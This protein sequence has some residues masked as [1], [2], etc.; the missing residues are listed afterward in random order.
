LSAVTSPHHQGPEEISKDEQYSTIDVKRLP[1]LKPAFKRDGGTITAANASSINDGAAAFVVTSGKT[2]K[3][4]GLK[5][6]AKILGELHTHLLPNRVLI[7]EGADG[8]LT[9]ETEHHKPMQMEII[10]SFLCPPPV[11]Q[12]SATR[13]GTRW[14]SPRRRRWP[15]P[16]RSSTRA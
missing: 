1:T 7:I 16:S 14:T 13:N 11:P 12:D 6:L 15:F 5:P 8:E 3:D 10:M 9:R 4:L 2:A